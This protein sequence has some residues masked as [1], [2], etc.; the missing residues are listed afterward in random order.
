MR[1][2]DFRYV[3]VGI[4]SPDETA[5]IESGKHQNRNVDLVHAIRTITRHGMIVNGGF[6]LGFDTETERTADRMIDLIQRTAIGSAMVGTLT[7]LPNTRLTKRLA[8][9]GRLFYKTNLSIQDGDVEVDNTTSGLNFATTRPRHELLLDHARIL[10]SVYSP[11]AYFRRVQQ[12]ALQL[13]RRPGHRPSTGA[14]L[15]AAWAGLRV[16]YIVTMHWGT[17]RHFWK[18]LLRV[19]LK[20]P[21]SAESVVSMAALYTHYGRQA[22][23]V[24]AI[25]EQRAEYVLRVGDGAY[26][27]RM[28]AGAR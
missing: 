11:R 5:L 12:T 7:A 18:A 14:A 26:N 28:L 4:E 3:F 19:L 23:F 20:N 1:D 8:S 22:A 16:I 6:I 9:E 21:G 15:R 13:F 25:Q 17:G 2:S 10:R 24:A 27:E